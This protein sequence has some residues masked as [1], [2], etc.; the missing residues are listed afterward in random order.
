MWINLQRIALNIDF[1]FKFALNYLLTHCDAINLTVG[2]FLINNIG[3]L[4][5]D[6]NYN[7]K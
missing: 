1:I 4:Y 7:N 3:L 5:V 2:K 6:V